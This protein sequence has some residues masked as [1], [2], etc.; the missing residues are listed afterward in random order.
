MSICITSIIFTQNHVFVV[1][2]TIHFF[3]LKICPF[4]FLVCLFVFFVCDCYD[5]SLWGG[6]TTL[7]LLCRIWQASP[8]YSTKWLPRYNL[9]CKRPSNLIIM[10]CSTVDTRR[11]WLVLMATLSYRATYLAKSL[12]FL[13]QFRSSIVPKCYPSLPLLPLS[14][15]HLATFIF[16]L[17]LYSLL[18]FSATT[19]NFSW[20]LMLIFC[21]LHE[22]STDPITT[23]IQIE[24]L[25]A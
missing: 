4:F 10:L 1:T 20:D 2:I 3:L 14:P 18:H 9:F 8:S 11:G 22:F 16:L 13:M 5:D 23:R 24:N 7:I 25:R 17:P 19:A 15:A 21:V 12:A 6:T